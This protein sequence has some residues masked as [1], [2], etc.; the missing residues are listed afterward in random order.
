MTFH[1]RVC[2]TCVVHRQLGLS[3]C[4]DTL[5]CLSAKTV[6]A[7]TG[8][9][10]SALYNASEA[11]RLGS[12]LFL[13]LSPDRAAAV[14]DLA[15]PSALP[16]SSSH[17]PSP[18]GPPSHPSHRSPRAQ[19]ADEDSATDPDTKQAEESTLDV[20]AGPTETSVAQ[21]GVR[22]E[23]GVDGVGYWQVTWLYLTSLLKLGEVYEVAGSHEDA[24]HAFTEG[25]ELVSTTQLS[26]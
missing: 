19:D 12:T 26:L 13:S 11:L 22:G 4:K 7:P 20:E 18:S 1:S 5:V 15:Q 25:Q 24:L 10:T 17:Q 14:T 21:E 6:V 8:Q 2:F 16:S 9:I 3:L 23:V